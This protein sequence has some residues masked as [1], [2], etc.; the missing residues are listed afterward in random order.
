MVSQG[1]G[2]GGGGAV[3]DK[4]DYHPGRPLLRTDDEAESSGRPSAEHSYAGSFFEQVAEGIQKRDRQKM[5]VQLSRYLTF[6]WAIINC[7][8]AGSITCFSVYAPLFQK[9][10]H[11][12]QLRVNTISI[13]AELAMYL[14]VPIFGFLCDRY[15]PGIPSLLSGCFAGFGYVLAAFTYRNPDWPFAVM[16][17]SFVWVGMATSC[18]YLSAVTTCAKNF[19]R[20]KHKGLALALPIAAFG[21]SGMWESQVGSRLLYEKKPDG[22]PGDIDVF[23]FFIFLGCTLFAAGAVGFFLLRIIDEDEMIDQAIEE[24]EQSGLLEDSA[25]FRRGQHQHHHESYGAVEEEDDEEE[26]QRK[27]EEA[28]KKTW[29]LNEETS[30]FLSDR[31]MWLLAGGFFLVTG[32]GEAFINNLGTVIGTLYPPTMPDEEIPTSAA[33]HVSI[34]AITSTIAR[35]LTGTL[36]DLFAPTSAPHQH[37]RGPNSLM[38]SMAT[39]PGMDAAEPPKRLEISRITFLLIFS[40]IMSIGQAVLASGVIQDHGERFWWVSAAVGAGYGAVFSLTPIITSVVWGV[41]NFGTNWACVATVPALGATLWGLLYSAVYQYAANDN[42]EASNSTTSQRAE[43][44]VT[45]AKTCIEQR[46]LQKATQLAKEAASLAP[47]NQNVQALIQY[48]SKEDS[49]GSQILPLIKSYVEHGNESDGR[50]AV[51]LLKQQA[52]VPSDHVTDI[53]HLLFDHDGKP[54]EVRD[55]LTGAFVINSAAARKQ[56]ANRIQVGTEAT[57]YF[58]LLWRRGQYSFNSILPV[59]LDADAWPTSEIQTQ[60]KRDAFLL[61]LG[62][63]LDPALEHGEWS[64]TLIAR[65][66]T[67]N[68]HDMAGLIDRDAFEIV[69]AQLDIRLNTKIRAQATLAVAK[70]LEETREEG[71]TIFTEYVTKSVSK[72][73]NDELIVAFSAAASVFPLVPQTVAKLFLTPGFLEGLVPVLER[74]TMGQRTSH[75]L[76]QAAMELMSAACVDKACRESIAKIA[77]N[78]LDDVAHTSTEAEAASMAALVLAKIPP[79]PDSEQSSVTH[80]DDLSSL[81]VKLTMNAS[82]PAEHQS[83]IEGLAYTSLQPKIKAEIV[84]NTALLKK[85]I[86]RLKST[87]TADPCTFGI[88]TIF[89]NLVS[90][91]PA[92]SEE[93]QKISQLRNYA[94]AK[95]PE[96]KDPLDD[97]EQVSARCKTVLDADLVPVL[98]AAARS[99]YTVTILGI[100]AKILHSLAREQKYRGKLAQQG[101]VKLLLQTIDRLQTPT[102]PASSSDSAEAAIHIA[103][104]ALARILISVN[105]QHVFSRAMPA[106]SALRPLVLLLTPDTTSDTRDLLPVFES[107][108]ALTNLASLEDDA[109]KDALLRQAWQPTEDLLLSTNK[110]VQRAAVELVC[111]LMASPAGVAKYA[112]GS[113]AAKHRL[114][115]LL[116]LADAEDLAT[117]RAAGGALAMLTEWDAAAKAVLEHERGVGILLDMCGD[118]SDEIKHRGLVCILNTISAPGEIG[119]LGMSKV[120]EQNG[121]EE[122]KSALRECRDTNVMSIGV[123]VLKAIMAEDKN[124][125]KAITQEQGSVAEKK[126]QSICGSCD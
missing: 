38:S 55:E 115:V 52:A 95:K 73:H 71:E 64:M 117:R 34:V 113:A 29:L 90:Y 47:T 65:L 70:L 33:T 122:I 126:G 87:T 121:L 3:I 22:T 21:L 118:D 1:S 46:Q 84:S 13:T 60:A 53:A 16:V 91:R 11:Y 31:S 37:R 5:Q 101:A 82:S 50:E 97:D 63:L 111:N 114:H 10:L 88:L 20:G 4:L 36:S 12:T 106:I 69:L 25:F 61:A 54:T 59:L 96:E 93:Q 94:E 32:P 116:A 124:R 2:N 75:R 109:V 105:P 44:L 40:L 14:P 26:R 30:R 74:N 24:L 108:L 7:L 9:R 107:L 39:L 89:S 48:L 42:V 83:S 102:G 58:R 66:L 35:I 51:R 80:A 41:E 76:E 98:V 15:G 57:R 18:M 120:K 27:E 72:G 81:L 85:L 23:R 79:K 110:L 17:F 6:A 62:K 100:A 112:D 104:H 92:Q 125:G 8:V 49:A 99:H 86:E 28:R 77:Y 123:E 119:T 78:W 56:L 103:A 43:E 67:S 68:A 45:Q 19:G